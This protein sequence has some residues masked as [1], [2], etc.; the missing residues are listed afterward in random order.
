MSTQVTHRYDT[1]WSRYVQIV[2]PEELRRVLDEAGET[3]DR[4]SH[5]DDEDEWNVAEDA[6]EP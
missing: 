2:S 1:E 5:L 4:P 6:D 3:Y